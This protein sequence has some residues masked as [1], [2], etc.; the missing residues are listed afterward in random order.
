MDDFFRG[1]FAALL[2]VL[3]TLLVANF[4]VKNDTVQNETW[5]RCQ[6]AYGQSHIPFEGRDSFM[7]GCFEAK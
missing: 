6:T 5:D 4:A 1:Y 7:R 2:V 3:F